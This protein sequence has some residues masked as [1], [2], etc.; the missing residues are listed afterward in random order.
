MVTKHREIERVRLLSIIAIPVVLMLPL[1]LTADSAATTNSTAI[2]T[3]TTTN[4]A[5]L[6]NGSSSSQL[7]N[8]TNLTGALIKCCTPVLLAPIAISG[9]N[10]YIVW[11]SNTTGDFEILFRASGDNGQTFSDKLNLSNTPGVDSVDP[12][13]GTLDNH[14]YISWWE[15]Y[16]NGTSVPF[17]RASS[18]NGDTF[19]QALPLFNKGPIAV[20]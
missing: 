6:S 14:V 5:T 18:N 3:T 16:G 10:V 11:S 4:P 9:N 17:F 7:A 1:V 8:S 2:T 19:E 15:D 13:I 20:Q 12:Q